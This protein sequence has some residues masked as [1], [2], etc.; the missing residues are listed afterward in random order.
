MV[1]RVAMTP[2]KEPKEAQRVVCAAIGSKEELA[3]GCQQLCVHCPI[4]EVREIRRPS[5]IDILE[6]LHFFVELTN[7]AV[8]G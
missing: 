3:L 6:I 8:T 1:D 4:Q 5:A 2:P 7:I